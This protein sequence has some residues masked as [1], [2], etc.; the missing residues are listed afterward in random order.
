MK[1]IVASNDFSK[2]WQELIDDASKA[3]QELAP[4][5]MTRSEFCEKTGMTKE[6]A[7]NYIKKL[8]K[9][10]KAEVDVRTINSHRH[11]IFRLLI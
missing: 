5:E 10:G 6:M 4:N 11:K 7:E 9:E 8:I 3:I 1:T 2:K